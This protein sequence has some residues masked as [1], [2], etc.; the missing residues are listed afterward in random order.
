MSAYKVGRAGHPALWLNNCIVA[1]DKGPCRQ[2]GAQPP[3]H[4]TPSTDDAEVARDWFVRFE[5]RVCSSACDEAG[6][7]AYE[8][9]LRSSPSERKT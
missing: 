9:A 3:L 8:R 7:D 5:A 6:W 4:L 2:C 1:E